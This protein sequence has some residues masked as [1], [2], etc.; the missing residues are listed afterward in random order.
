MNP[1]VPRVGSAATALGA[2]AVSGLPP[3]NGFVSEWL[4]LLGLVDAVT[5]R[6]AYSWAAM[7]AVIALAMAGALALATFVK[8]GA[9]MFLGAPR[10]KAAARAHECGGWMRGP[11]FVLAGACVVLGLAPALFWPAISRA[12]G[13]WDAAWAS[14]VAPA[15]L[16][17][18]GC[19]DVALAVLAA[20]A[21]SLLWRKA[22]ASGLTRRLTWDCGYAAPTARM[23]YT[24]GSFAGLA[25]GWF[26]WI[27]RP[28]RRSRRPRGPFPTT[29]IRLE[30]T[31][32]TVLERLIVP[33]TARLMR[34]STAIRRLQHGRLQAYVLYVVV[35]LV[36]LAALV[37]LGGAS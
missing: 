34:V 17:T 22:R 21:G 5:S 6:A 19:I 1:R 20:A 29:A 30:R 4:V 3:L 32:E 18:L 31:P 2:V 7:P 28:K 33:A 24:S 9:T 23:Q 16:F 12:V 11:M 14:T 26:A 35:G 27:L 13:V 37:S 25:T 15:P 36:A 10:T 8:A